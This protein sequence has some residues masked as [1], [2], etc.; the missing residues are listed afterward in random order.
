MKVKIKNLGPIKSA[1][2][3]L[4]DF[5]VITGQNNTGKTYL[6]YAVYG[7]LKTWIVHVKKL[8]IDKIISDILANGRIDIN[9][10][11]YEQEVINNFK[12]ISKIYSQNINRVF[13]ANKEEFSNTE[14]IVSLPAT[15]VKYEKGF[16]I[17]FKGKNITK[18]ILKAEK[19]QKKSILNIEILAESKA[20][21]PP[22]FVLAKILNELINMAVLQDF[23]PTPFIITSERTGIHIFQKELDIN[24]NVLF[25]KLIKASK[26]KFEFNPFEFIE[27]VFNRYSMP[28]QDSIERVRDKDKILKNTSFIYDEYGE[29]IRDFEK[30]ISGLGF[31]K[32]KNDYM[33]TYKEGR[34]K[35]MLP[36]YLASSSARALLDLFIYIKYS[37]N[38]NDLLIIDEPELN[39]HP[40]LQIKMTRLLA[41]LSNI[42]IKILITTHSD[43]IVKEIN[44][45]LMLRLDFNNKVEF[46]EKYRYNQY[47]HLKDIN[48]Y[49]AEKNTLTKIAT[50][51]F[52]LKRTTFDKTI[53]LINSISEELYDKLD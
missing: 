15:R 9:L 40:E 22:K 44:N 14:F 28:I 24:K 20:E 42:G 49:I 21:Y 4:S 29:L 41:A 48:F 30:S 33:V 10:K 23:F 45:L 51:K 12:P 5:N 19:K 32:Y 2:F 39:L 37:A 26:E 27:D 53:D 11:E 35:I 25:E 8:K 6:S 38:K 3:E 50:D 52:G 36:L 47:E 16:A 46:I 1:D 43:Y 31:K 17:E 7:F 18:S 13:S 34:K